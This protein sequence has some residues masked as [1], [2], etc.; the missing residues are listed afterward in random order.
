MK[1]SYRLFDILGSLISVLLGLAL[2]LLLA[3]FFGE[4]P[5][6]VLKILAY[7]AFGNAYNVGMTL[8]YAT[9]LI[10]AGLAVALPFHAG[11]FNMGGEGQLVMGALAAAT[12]GILFPEMNAGMAPI[13][14]TLAA[15]T[16][17]AFW[18][19]IPGWLRAKRGSHEVIN[20]IMMNFV[21]AGCSSYVTLYLLKN[22]LSQNPETKAIGAGFRIQP[23]AWFGDAPLSVMFPF[24]IIVAWF[25]AIFLWKMVSGFELRVTGENE[26]AAQVAGIDSGRARL[27][28][29]A[30]GGGL[31][32]LG[33]LGEVLVNSGRFKPDAF[34]GLGFMG[35]AVALLGRSKPSGVVISAILFGALHKGTS[36]LDLETETLTRD[37]SQILQALIIICVAMSAVLGCYGEKVLGLLNVVF[38]K[39]IQARRKT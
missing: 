23:L 8:F 35:V 33:G 17:G 15:F 38:K 37:F 10:F 14:A 16:A 18:G 29:M 4:N 28:A 24:A 34:S 2:G 19:A 1:N 31:A 13:A 20:T 26:I 36:E 25:V 6:K 21:A 27:I 39:M 9:P 5:A 11:L 22:T 30:L 12:I 7:G 32:G 3:W